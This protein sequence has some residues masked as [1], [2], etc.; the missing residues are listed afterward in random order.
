MTLG[1]A[2]AARVEARAMVEFVALEW[3]SQQKEKWSK[4][5]SDAVLATLKADVF[6]AIGDHPIDIIQPPMVFS[7]FVQL[8]HEGLW[9]LPL[10]YCKG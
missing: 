6:P 5:H 8:S 7:Y 2:R 1:K 10:K 3:I 9:R 4:P